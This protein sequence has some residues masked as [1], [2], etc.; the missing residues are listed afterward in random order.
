[1]PERHYPGETIGI[2]GS[3]TQS[4]LFAQAAGKLGYRIGSL[5]LDSNNPVRQ[6]ASWQTVAEVLDEDVLNYF[7][8]RCDV[9]VTE[10]GLLSSQDLNLLNLHCDIPLSEDLRAISTDRL[11]EKAYL[12]ANRCLV[13]PFSMI[14]SLEDLKEAVE[15][16]GFPCILKSAQ[17][18]LP[19]SNQHVLLYSEEDYAA[20]I[21]KIEIGTCLLEAWIPAEKKISL[22]VVRN[23][24]GELL[25]YPPFELIQATDS[26][27]Q[28]VRF[29]V[30]LHDD[31]EREIL[32]LGRQIAT[33]TE[34]VG[35]MT[36]EFLMTS[37]GVV[38][39]N[40][41]SIGLEESAIFSLG[42]LSM[43]HFE[44]CA[45][46]VV[47]LPLPT[48]VPTTP[49][50]IAYPLTS[51]KIA[52]VITQ[53]MLRTDWEFVLFNPVGNDPQ[54]L[55]G[56]VIITGDSIEHCQRQADITDLIRR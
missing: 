32:R 23:E 19:H 33:S 42:A 47:G 12:D 56:H 53:Y 40:K 27:S 52:N 46:A 8:G 44:A 41:A 55:N 5:V 26:E 51:L 6:F 34:L 17:R 39:I 4:A 1:M 16:I 30:N 9:I 24:R 48:L 20:A 21:E 35:T 25:S 3:G 11:I 13:A 36:F 43:S 15:Y 45:R 22:T 49:A 28:Q 54:D 10:V 18:H 38:Y 7:A 14:T 31:V 50:A 2:I 37:A 29:P